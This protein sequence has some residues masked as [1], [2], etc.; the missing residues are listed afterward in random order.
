MSTLLHHS[1]SIDNE[2]EKMSAE[3]VVDD[4]NTSCH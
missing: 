2:D 3:A 4:D 1:P